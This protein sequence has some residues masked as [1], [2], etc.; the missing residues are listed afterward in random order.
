[1]SPEELIRQARSLPAA[2]KLELVEPL[3]TELDHPDECVNAARAAEDRLDAYREGE[4]RAIP[5]ADVLA[6]YRVR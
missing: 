6:K 2:E 3:L 1:M 4:I 5:L